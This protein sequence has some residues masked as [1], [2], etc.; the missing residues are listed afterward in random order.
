VNDIEL[1]DHI[2][3]CGWSE[4]A[5]GI[6]QQIRADTVG[7]R[8]HIVLIDPDLDGPPINDPFL[9][10]VKG[11][12]SEYETLE[13]AFIETAETALILADWSLNDPGLRD[14]KTA[15]TTL[16][17]E[18]YASQV[19]TV[20]E[21]MRAES[22]RH[23]EHANVDEPV[24]VSE[25]SQRLLVHAAMNHG[26]SRF[27]TDVLSYGEGSEI[28]KVPLPSLLSGMGFREAVRIISD[29]FEAIL[30]AVER[31][32]QIHCNPQGEWEFRDG[33]A[34]FVLAEDYPVELERFGETASNGDAG[35]D[36]S[37]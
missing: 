31:E 17:I 23:L 4:T 13:K 33:D 22:R 25:I 37:S 24:C 1:R 18:S 14:S 35:S 2:V 32:E 36:S 27:F 19:Y 8:R 15:L 30:L 9:Y 20:A 10:F 28:Y 12:P 3:I 34:L 7:R 29:R 11:D 6:I 5:R 21:V 16:A 26:L